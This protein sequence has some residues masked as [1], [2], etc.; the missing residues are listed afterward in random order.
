VGVSVLGQ[1]QGV[2]ARWLMKRFSLSLIGVLLLSLLVSSCGKRPE[3]LHLAFVT[4]NYL[5]FWRIA[6][7][8]CEEARMEFEDVDVDFRVPVTGSLDE[9]RQIM[10]ELIVVGVD[11]IAV[12]P[13][14]PNMQTAFLNEVASQT[15]LVCQD[16]DAPASNRVCYIGTDNV[17]AGMEVGR[18]LLE[19]LPEGGEVMVFVGTMAAQ[20][21]VARYDGILKAVEGTEVKVLGVMEDQMDPVRARNN[22]VSAL[23]SHTGIDCLVGLWSYNGPALLRAVSSEGKVGKVK[24]ICFDEDEQTLKGVAEGSIYAT[25]VQQPFE[26]GRQ[27]VSRMRAYLKGDLDALGGDRIIIPTLVIKQHNVEQYRTRLEKMLSQ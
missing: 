17:E 11:G 23:N 27:S 21:A 10:N 16:S 2:S 20:N 12:S 8:G 19:A 4:N 24:I 13:V 22:A 1:A 15:L 18:L 25:V 3:R 26:F 5:D 7:A 6:K 14:D 9:Q